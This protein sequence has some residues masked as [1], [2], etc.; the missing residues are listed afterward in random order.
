[1][2]E[3]ADLIEKSPD[4]SVRGMAVIALG[5]TASRH[6]V[7]TLTRCFTNVSYRNGYRWR[8]LYAISMIL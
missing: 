6:P 1:M 2:S 4:A 5:Y 8:T 3:F 7:S